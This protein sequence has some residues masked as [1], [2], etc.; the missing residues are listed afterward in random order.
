RRGERRLRYRPLPLRVH[1]GPVRRDGDPEPAPRVSERLRGGRS[2]QRLLQHLQA[3]GVER[4]A[5]ALVLLDR[6]AAHIDGEKAREDARGPERA[7]D[8]GLGKT[9]GRAQGPWRNACRGGDGGH[10]RRPPKR[11]GG[12]R[13]LFNGSRKRLEI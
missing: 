13:A 3:E 11:R 5:R 2:G 7:E 8:Q 9:G 12:R 4:G 6:A 10:L 1:K